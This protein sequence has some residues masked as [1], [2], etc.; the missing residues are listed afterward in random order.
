MRVK[1]MVPLL[2]LL[3]SFS[4][5]VAEEFKTLNADEVKRLMK[6]KTKMVLVDARTVQ[7]Y[8]EGHLPSAVN[9]PPDS[10]AGMG[11]VLP[12]KKDTLLIFYC[13]GAG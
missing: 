4:L 5:A 2:F 12:K 1:W 10:L 8:R 6:K 11:T 3:F 13:R 7:E 9:V